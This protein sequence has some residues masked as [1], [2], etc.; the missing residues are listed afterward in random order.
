MLRRCL[1]SLRRQS[2]DPSTLSLRVIVVDND[3]EPKARLVYDEFC[4]GDPA[5]YVHCSRPGI[6]VARNAALEAAL[7]MGADYIAF[8]D[9]DEVAPET[10][11]NTLLQTLQASN[12]DA[13]QGGVCKAPP[14]VEDIAAYTHAPTG[15]VSWEDSE[16][17]ATCNVLFKVGLVAAPLSLRFDE[18]MQFTG[19]SDREFFM[20]AHK[21][22]AKTVR[23][24]GVDVYEEVCEG[25]DSLGY[26]TKRAFASGNNYVARMVR[27]ETPPIAFARIVL[28]ALGSFLSAL[29]KLIL[30]A[31][32]T[33]AM[34]GA[35]AKKS[36]RKS[37]AMFAFAW[38]CVTPTFGLRAQPYRVIQGA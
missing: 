26:E 14:G 10:W 5:G 6:P 33:L 29:G 20:R 16:S 31:L 37:C 15:K 28:R 34:Q 25:R 21:H 9:D 35:K 2:F 36:W 3:P 22:G 1:E 19:G 17:L 27:N 18:S 4:G 24:H 30:A 13:I 38:G 12:A 7:G 32:L 8:I 11:V 23:V